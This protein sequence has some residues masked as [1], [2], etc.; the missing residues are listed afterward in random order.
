VGGIAHE[1]FPHTAAQQSQ[2]RAATSGEQRNDAGVS[3]AAP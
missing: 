1:A 3:S 2:A